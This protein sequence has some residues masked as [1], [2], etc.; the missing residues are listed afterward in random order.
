[1]TNFQVQA[2]PSRLHWLTPERALFFIP[3]LTSVGVAVALLCLA[4]LPM[5]RMVRER[6]VVVKDLTNKGLE[7]PQLERDLQQQQALNSQLEDQEI[8]LFKMLAGTK[9]LGTFLA[10][11]NSL[12]VKHQVTVATTEPGAIE[13]W[14]PPLEDEVMRGDDLDPDG[15]FSGS[16]DDL[17]LEGLEKRSALIEVQGIFRDVGVDL[18]RGEEFPPYGV[19][20][21][22]PRF[23]RV[24][25]QHCM[26][27]KD[28]L[29]CE[30]GLLLTHCGHRG[31]GDSP[32][33][34]R[35]TLHGNWFETD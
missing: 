26:W 24:G 32:L 17:L 3:V 14:V 28:S 16:N 6:Q 7:L 11:L 1:M 9:D 12:A 4:A 27:L 15:D 30:R 22:Y 8:R 25:H 2:S 19:V 18:D 31:V 35:V 13:S 5:F 33:R 10:G 20:R 21:R 29:C 23:A 34:K